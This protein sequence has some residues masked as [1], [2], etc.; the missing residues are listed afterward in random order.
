MFFSNALKPHVFFRILKFFFLLLFLW[1]RSRLAMPRALR[2][3][4]WN[5]H[6][7]V[8]P[9]SFDPAHA[10][11]PAQ[12]LLRLAFWLARLPVI[13]PWVSLWIKVWSLRA[14]IEHFVHF[15]SF[16]DTLFLVF[17]SISH[18]IQPFSIFLVLPT[19]GQ[20]QTAVVLFS[21]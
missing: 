15:S 8:R 21:F 9:F 4:F 12:A 17:L 10:I 11:F 19:R 18:R 20:S 2:L 1:L 6:E 16:C 14:E 3:L 7:S 5:L 13:L